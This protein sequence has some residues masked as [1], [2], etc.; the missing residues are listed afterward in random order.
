MA[1][2][3]R[4]SVTARFRT[5][6][7]CFPAK[8]IQGLTFCEGLPCVEEL[9]PLGTSR[10]AR[11]GAEKYRPWQGEPRSP[12]TGRRA[13]GRGDSLRRVLGREHRLRRQVLLAGRP[14][15][16]GAARSVCELR[17]LDVGGL[18]QGGRSLS[19][20]QESGCRAVNPRTKESM[21]RG[22]IPRSKGNS[23][24]V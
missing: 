7:C 18:S 11:P 16:A 9:H 1:P 14:R 8:I 13:P 20:C 5:S 24:E 2:S 4:H 23:P 12:P 3:R 19:G 6:L 10:E 21:L 17:N 22:G 15:P